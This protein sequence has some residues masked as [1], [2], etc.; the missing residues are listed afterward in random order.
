MSTMLADHTT[1]GL[2]GPAKAFRTASSTDELVAL[3][4]EADR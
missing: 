1:L 3:V 4:N 2:G